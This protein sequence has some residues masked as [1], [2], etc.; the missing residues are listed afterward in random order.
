MSLR[1]SDF[2]FRD[3]IKREAESHLLKVSDYPGD[4]ATAKRKGGDFLKQILNDACAVPPS[5]TAENL[6]AL[7]TKGM[8]LNVSGR[9]GTTDST[10]A[11]HWCGIF[12]TYVL[13][14][15]GMP[16]KWQSGVG[17]EPSGAESKMVRK[18]RRWIEKFDDDAFEV[19]DVAAIPRA[20]HHFVIVDVSHATQLGTVAGNGNYQ[21]IERQT[22]ERKDVNCLYK[23]VFDPLSSRL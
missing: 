10:K 22:H 14:R 20:N 1:S 4:G 18:Y 3:M 19:G 12:A 6:R 9:G 8:W 5:W 23:I 11:I 2:S 17:I 13:R 15:A 7:E 16:V 21:R